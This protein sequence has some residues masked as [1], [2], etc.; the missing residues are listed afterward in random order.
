MESGLALIGRA[1]K[2]IHGSGRWSPFHP[3]EQGGARKQNQPSRRLVFVSRR[4]EIGSLSAGPHAGMFWLCHAST[5]IVCH[6]QFGNSCRVNRMWMCE[7]YRLCS[8][9][10]AV[11]SRMAGCLC[12][13][14]T[15]NICSSARLR[16]GFGPRGPHAQTSPRDLPSSSQCRP[17][18]PRAAGEFPTQPHRRPA[19]VYPIRFHSCLVGFL[20]CCPNRVAQLEPP[21]RTPSKPLRPGL[22]P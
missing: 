6:Q 8:C 9:E 3:T 5:L 7:S 22:M 15:Q 12:I 17:R 4:L 14:T 1:Q 20:I 13:V 2:C 11:F 18:G 19:E 10:K 16:M 21:T